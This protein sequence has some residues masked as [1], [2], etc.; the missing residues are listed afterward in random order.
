M[1]LYRLI[2]LSLLVAMELALSAAESMITPFIQIP[3]IKLGLANIITLT[4]FSIVPRKQV[5]LVVLTRLLLAGLVL[6][7]F[8]TP[9]F[10]ISCA[11]GLLSFIAMAAFAGRRSIT[12]IGAS[13]AGA[14][15]HNCG[16]LAMVSVLM[17][18]AGICHYLPWMLIWSIPMGL[19]TGVSAR[20]ATAA[21]VRTGIKGVK[22]EEKK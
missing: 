6:G 22:K 2:T 16:Q 21:L 7:S 3:G 19:F 1:S 15:A 9:A 17:N 18:N 5:F 13:L 10:W 20:L 8:L 11:G 12:V 4:A 14:A